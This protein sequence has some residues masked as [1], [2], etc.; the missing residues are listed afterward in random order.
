MIKI[1][2]YKDI[3]LEKKEKIE[4]YINSEKENIVSFV[5]MKEKQ[6][7]KDRIKKKNCIKED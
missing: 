6:N 4:V 7:N 5:K 2:E 3:F 1:N